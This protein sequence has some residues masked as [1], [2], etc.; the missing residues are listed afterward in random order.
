[1]ININKNISFEDII[2]IIQKNIQIKKPIDNYFDLW[3][4][5]L[6][7][8]DKFYKEN[9]ND[10]DYDFNYYK[11][12]S[13]LSL[14]LIKSINIDIV[15]YGISINRFYN[16]KTIYDLYNSMNIRFGPV[17]NTISEYIKYEFFNSRVVDYNL[18]FDLDLNINDYYLLI[19]RLLFATYYFDLLKN[20]KIQNEYINIVNR[21]EDYLNYVKDIIIAIKKRQNDMSLLDYLINL[22]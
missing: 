5:K 15:T 9:Y 17:V 11:E 21:I 6:D 20:N 18:I 13:E 12:L 14:R 10:F 8:L 19:A 2:T 4:T 22:L 1:M 3:K 16:I 7:Y